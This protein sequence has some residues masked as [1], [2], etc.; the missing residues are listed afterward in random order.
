MLFIPKGIILAITFINIPLG[1]VNKMIDA[2]VNGNKNHPS[3]S[4]AIKDPLVQ[5]VQAAVGK[6]EFVYALRQ[7]S[8]TRPVDVL[9]KLAKDYNAT[10]A[11]PEYQ[12]ETFVIDNGKGGFSEVDVK[13]G[14][15]WHK[16]PYPI[17]PII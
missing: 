12:V 8:A 11:R 7:L 4:N 15:V 1:R 3:P 5:Q 14:E 6:T 16:G 2:F 13:S 17:L 9:I 10:R